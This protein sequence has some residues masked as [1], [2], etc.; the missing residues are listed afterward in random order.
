[1]FEHY[2]D[3]QRESLLKIYQS[4]VVKQNLKNPHPLI[5]Q[6]Q[7]VIK[8]VKKDHRNSNWVDIRGLHYSFSNYPAVM[9]TFSVTEGCF[10]RLYLFLDALFKAIESVGGKILIKGD[11]DSYFFIDNEKV[12]FR[13]KEK[14]TSAYIS[15]DQRNDKWDSGYRFIPT[16]KLIFTIYKG[17]FYNYRHNSEF[18]FSETP[19]RTLSDMLK[20]FLLKYLKF[21]S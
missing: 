2:D 12:R 13:I 3:I 18:I 4:L 8:K 20:T 17:F 11:A 21:H 19:H 1:M 9:D 14:Y 6:H 7:S 16:G 5:V 10:P 15:V